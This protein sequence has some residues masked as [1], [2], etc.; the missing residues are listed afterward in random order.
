MV[1]L[2]RWAGESY[3]VPGGRIDDHEHP[4]DHETSARAGTRRED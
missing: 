1:D 4:D 3:N 2:G